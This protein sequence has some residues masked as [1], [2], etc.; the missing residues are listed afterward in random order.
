MT[1][2]TPEEIA[3][4]IIVLI[5]LSR[6]AHGIL[7]AQ[8]GIDYLKRYHLWDAVT[9]KEKASLDNLT[10]EVKC[11]FSWEIEKVYMLMWAIKRVPEINFPSDLCAFDEMA[12]LIELVNQLEDPSDFIHSTSDL[13]LSDT[14]STSEILDMND[15][16]YRFNWACVDARINNKEITELNSSVAYMRQFAL[17]WL[18]NYCDQ[19][20]DN[21]TCDT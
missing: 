21:V 11:D 16:Y 19:D 20:W 13:S 5:T 17:N 12:P 10:E 6:I 9:S 15:L 18:I 7:D 1:L 8:N 3:T 14:R 4:R 2:R